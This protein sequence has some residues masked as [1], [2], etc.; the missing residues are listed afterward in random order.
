MGSHLQFSFFVL[1]LTV[2]W[3]ITS[4]D[5]RSKKRR[6]RDKERL[7]GLQSPSC[8]P[9]LQPTRLSRSHILIPTEESATRTVSFSRFMCTDF[10]SS[11][12]WSMSTRRPGL[13]KHDSSYS[14][15]A[16]FATA[17]N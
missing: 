4:C 10:R 6:E 9:A 7:T 3:T 8:L 16:F 2:I 1:L 12:Q 14:Y 5:V 11:D 13:F 17:L 15:A